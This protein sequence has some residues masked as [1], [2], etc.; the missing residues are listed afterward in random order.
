MEASNGKLKAKRIIFGMTPPK[1]ISAGILTLKNTG[2]SERGV[3]C[4]SESEATEPVDILPRDN[5]NNPM[6][7]HSNTRESRSDCGLNDW[8]LRVDTPGRAL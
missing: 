4:Q 5:G 3:K 8:E 1:F 7:R 2:N 6:K